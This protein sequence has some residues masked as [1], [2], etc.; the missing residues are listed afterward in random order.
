VKRALRYV[1]MLP[2]LIYI[3]ALLPVSY[4]PQYT[5]SPFRKS[6]PTVNIDLSAA[7]AAGL[8]TQTVAAA[9]Q[10]GLSKVSNN[11]IKQACEPP[12]LLKPIVR[13]ARQVVVRYTSN[14]RVVA[15]KIFNCSNYV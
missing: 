6:D 14:G 13:P 15:E 9:A 3:W 10:T 2:G 4:R 8:G 7:A 5:G 11:R 12:L 1:V